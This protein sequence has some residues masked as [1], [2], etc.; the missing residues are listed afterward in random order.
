MQIKR[1]PGIT[2]A[3]LKDADF[4]FDVSEEAHPP[5]EDFALSRIVAVAPH[6]KRYPIDFEM[7]ARTDPGRSMIAAANDVRRIVGYIAVLRAWNHC[8]QV[9]DFAVD[10]GFRHHGIGRLLMHEAIAWAHELNLPMLRLETQSNNVPACR[11]Y[12]RMGFR[13]GGFDRH[14][15][16]AIDGPQQNEIALFWYL[17][18]QQR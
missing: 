17:R 18:L 10:R 14:L 1:V 2:A 3:E 12:Q 15:Y 7:L 5:F 9:E 6:R 16:S 11:F 13:L 4:S 8:A